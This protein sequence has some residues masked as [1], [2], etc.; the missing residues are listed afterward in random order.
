M[1]CFKITEIN[2]NFCNINN[3]LFA[4]MHLEKTLYDSQWFEI[5]FKEL[6][7]TNIKGLKYSLISFS[8]F[9]S[10]WLEINNDCPYS[11]NLN[12]VEIQKYWHAL[13]L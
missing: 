4:I 8:T 7:S 10:A 11:E 9:G 5:I 1:I 12:S 13:I 3:S 6:R 2:E